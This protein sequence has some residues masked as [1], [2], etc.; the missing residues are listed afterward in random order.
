MN[1]KDF[2]STTEV[3]N[4]LGI[5]RIAVFNKIKKG[6]LKATKNGRNFLIARKD[7]P[8][9]LGLVLGEKEKALIYQAVTKA[10]NQYGET[11]RLLGQD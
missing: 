10:V 8:V 5:S 4:A 9:V 1:N 2:L 7:L 11:F 6:Q 3:A